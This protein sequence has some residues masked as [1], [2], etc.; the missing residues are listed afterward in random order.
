[1]GKSLIEYNEKYARKVATKMA[2]AAEAVQ[3]VTNLRV[4]KDDKT[5][6]SVNKKAQEANDEAILMGQMFFTAFQKTIENIESVAEEFKRT[7]EELDQSINGLFNFS[8]I[9]DQ[10]HT[11][12]KAKRG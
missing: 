4:I 5:T 11:Y 3:H 9:L 1:M 2:N 12:N 7:D 8:G 10:I 6:L